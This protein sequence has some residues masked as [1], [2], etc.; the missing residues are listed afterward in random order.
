MGVVKSPSITFP[1]T[2]KCLGNA[3]VMVH[4]REY[5]GQKYVLSWNASM[6][7]AGDRGA[8]GAS[9]RSSDEFMEYSWK[10]RV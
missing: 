6:Y 8:E 1:S 7:A 9:G 4:R 3:V 5:K 10:V 2:I